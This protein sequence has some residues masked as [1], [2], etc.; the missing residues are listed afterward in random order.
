MTRSRWISECL[1]ATQ[2]VGISFWVKGNAPTG[3]AKFSV[4]MRE[5]QPITPSKAEYKTGTCTGTDT[6]DPPTCVH[7]S[8]TFTLT[9]TWQ[10]IQAPWGDFTPGNANG[11][12][13]PVDGHNIW[14]LQF[15]IALNWAQGGDGGWAPVPAAYDL[16]VDS[17]TFL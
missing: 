7:P 8:F 4:N 17:M 5:T 15:D 11:T 2:F 14:Q 10:Q 12:Q 13:V 1:D 6:G 9:D 16:I 3:Q